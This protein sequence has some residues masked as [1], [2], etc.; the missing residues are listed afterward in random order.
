MQIREYRHSATLPS[1]VGKA[2]EPKPPNRRDA[3]L[4]GRGPNKNQWDAG[5]MVSPAYGFWD[6]AGFRWRAGGGKDG[7]GSGSLG[8]VVVLGATFV[9]SE[10][11]QDVTL[12]PFVGFWAG[13]TASRGGSDVRVLETGTLVV[14]AL[15]GW[16]AP[17]EVV[18]CR[19]GFGTWASR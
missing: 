13:S 11:V 18:V 19:E 14:E 6:G 12:S 4:R 3:H 8:V 2:T 1:R 10:W 9:G 5:Q 16:G 17:G 7:G 15:P